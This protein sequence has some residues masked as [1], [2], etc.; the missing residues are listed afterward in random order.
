MFDILG[1]SKEKQYKPFTTIYFYLL[2]ID[3]S[4]TV[5]LLN[6]ND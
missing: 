5:S 4:E 3:N 2:L 1:S 6:I